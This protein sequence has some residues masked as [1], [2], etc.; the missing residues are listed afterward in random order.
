MQSNKTNHILL[1]LVNDRCH[2]VKP[3]ITHRFLTVI[4]TMLL[5]L[6]YSYL[7]SIISVVVVLVTVVVVKV[8]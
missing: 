7:H 2:I 1:T 4:C 3:S 6:Q 8:L 5:P